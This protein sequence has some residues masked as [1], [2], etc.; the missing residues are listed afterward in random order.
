MAVTRSLVLT[1]TSYASADSPNRQTNVGA[2]VRSEDLCVPGVH[3]YPYKELDLILCAL[4]P[5]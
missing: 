1:C 4:A 3:T 2:K 5:A